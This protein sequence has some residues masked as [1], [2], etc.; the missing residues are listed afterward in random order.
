MVKISISNRLFRTRLAHI[1]RARGLDS[2]HRI[3]A[4]E[5]EADLGKGGFQLIL[6]ADIFDL[7]FRFL[8]AERQQV[9]FADRGDRG[10]AIAHLDPLAE[11]VDRNRDRKAR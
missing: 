3:A 4:A 8:T 11:T 5:I 2:P 1:R 6:T 7:D 9:D 10:E